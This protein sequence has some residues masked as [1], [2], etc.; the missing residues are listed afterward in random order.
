MVAIALLCLGIIPAFETTT[1]LPSFKHEHEPVS[2]HLLPISSHLDVLFLFLSYILKKNTNLLVKGRPCPP[3]PS[4]VPRPGLPA[5][6]GDKI[7]IWTVSRD[8]G[9]ARNNSYRKCHQRDNA[10]RWAT[11]LF[12]ITIG[13]GLG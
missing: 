7:T 8:S 2:D 13:N 3:H 10:D 12:A 9:N 6:R 11:M 5:L 1:V 4:R